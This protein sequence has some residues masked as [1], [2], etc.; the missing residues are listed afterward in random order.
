M[1]A[2]RNRSLQESVL[3]RRANSTV[4]IQSHEL[5]QNSSGEI[6]KAFT[7]FETRVG[8]LLPIPAAAQGERRSTH[9]LS[10]RYVDGLQRD[11]QAVVNGTVYEIH[12]IVN[13][14]QRGREHVMRIR[15]LNG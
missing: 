1:V 9:T 5:N 11:M 12:N 10:I 6:V 15:Q 4:T 2:K 7:D 8:L 14:D 3:K 13:V